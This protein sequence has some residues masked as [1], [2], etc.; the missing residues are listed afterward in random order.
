MRLSLL[1]AVLAASLHAQDLATGEA[2]FNS[3]CAI[4]HGTDGSGAR[5]PNLRGRLRNGDSTAEIE[6]VIS[7]GLPGTA[8]PKFSFEPDELQGVV[9]YVQSFHQAGASR[10]HPEG[11][12]VAGKIVYDSHGCSGC[13]E[14]GHQGST[15]GPN[16]TRI[17]ASRSYDYLKTSIVDPSADVPDEYQT[18]RIVTKDGKQV[19]GVWVNEDSFTVQIRLS[20]E[21]YASFDKQSLKEEVH[22]KKSLMPAYHL[23][24]IDLKN[25]LSYL[26]DLTSDAS[27][28]TETQTER[29]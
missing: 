4:C 18:V 5:G 22:E 7:K 12:K 21:S 13:H 16:L 27:G 2:I 19:Q 10:P 26:S 6:A 8:M 29:R 17:G 9:R 23:S 25:L 20:D 14:I 24:D 28:G 15:L 1:A 11:D 3:N